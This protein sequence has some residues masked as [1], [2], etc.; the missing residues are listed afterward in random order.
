[1]SARKLPGGAKG[2]GH[3]APNR[4]KN[5]LGVDLRASNF[6]FVKDD[7]GLSNAAAVV[8]GLPGHFDLEEVTIAEDAIEIDLFERDA[9]PAF[10]SASQIAKG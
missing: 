6:P 2:Q 10:E 4:L 7:R 9:P 3:N 5:N 8:I 1:M